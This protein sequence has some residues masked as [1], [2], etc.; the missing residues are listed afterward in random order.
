MPTNIENFLLFSKIEGR[1]GLILTCL[2]RAD[3]VFCS[4]S[5]LR[6]KPQR[7]AELGFDAIG[8]PSAWI[9]PAFTVPAKTC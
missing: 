6:S 9:W 8:S 7:L 5:S 3:H 2:G 1:L 4:V